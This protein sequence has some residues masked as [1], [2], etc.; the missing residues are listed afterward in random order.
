[1]EQG[2]ARLQPG[3]EPRGI[4]HCNGSQRCERAQLIVRRLEKFSA[5]L[6]ELINQGLR[7]GATRYTAATQN[8]QVAELKSRVDSG[9][10]HRG[11]EA[12]LECNRVSMAQNPET[13]V[14]F[15]VTV[16]VKRERK[17]GMKGRLFAIGIGFDDSID[18]VWQDEV[19]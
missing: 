8:E 1:L 12:R 3:V 7:L 11:L 4:A 18:G 6:E 9:C 5:R 15:T 2:L 10:G 17:A 16:V 13:V 19:L 14:L